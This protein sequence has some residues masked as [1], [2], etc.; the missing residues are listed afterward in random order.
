MRL[1]G[2]I[3]TDNG[4]PFSGTGILGPLASMTGMVA[5]KHRARACTEILSR[6]LS[7]LFSLGVSR[8]DISLFREEHADRGS[9]SDLAISVNPEA[10]LTGKRVF[11]VLIGTSDST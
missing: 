11:P 5:T 8:G 7:F 9:L 1:P 6:L 2:R 3:R 10:P 4:A